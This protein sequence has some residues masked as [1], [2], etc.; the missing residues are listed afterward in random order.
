MTR[1]CVA[2]A[3]GAGGQLIRVVRRGALGRLACQDL[4]GHRL[5]RDAL[6]PSHGLLA[7]PLA[8]RGRSLCRLGDGLGE[9][10]ADADDGDLALLD[11]RGL[12]PL[13]LGRRARSA[14]RRRGRHHPRDR[15]DL[16]NLKLLLEVA[17]AGLADL[18]DPLLARFDAI[19]GW[20]IQNHALAR[21]LGDGDHEGGV[22]GIGGER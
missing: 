2:R 3:L 4:A 20:A 22:L 18:A 1:L 12:G 11:L 17:D 5:E 21:R 7:R 14:V 13:A 8:A 10:I 15:P 16:R 6:D 9:S 19:A